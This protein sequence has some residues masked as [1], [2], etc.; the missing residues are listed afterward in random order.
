MT[1]EEEIRSI[2]NAKTVDILHPPILNT[3]DDEQEVHNKLYDEFNEKFVTRGFPVKIV[4]FRKFNKSIR[5]DSSCKKWGDVHDSLEDLI[6]FMPESVMKREIRVQA[7]NLISDRYTTGSKRNPKHEPDRSMLPAKENK[8]RPRSE[9]SIKSSHPETIKIDNVWSVEKID[10]FLSHRG[11][12]TMNENPNSDQVIPIF[13]GQDNQISFQMKFEDALMNNFE[14]NINTSRSFA[15]CVAQE[16]ILSTELEESNIETPTI[17]CSPD[18]S[19]SY[20][21]SKIVP[22]SMSAP[23]QPLAEGII[24]PAT[25]LPSTKVL[26]HN[27]NFW[28]SG[29]V[30]SAS[31]WHHDGNSNILLVLHGRKLIELCPPDTIQASAIYSDHANHPAVLCTKDYNLYHLNRSIKETQKSIFTERYI[32]DISAGDSIFIPPGWWHRVESYGPCLAVNIWFNTRSNSVHSL[33]N[34]DNLHMLSF[35]AR[36]LVRLYYTN[37]YIS[38]AVKYM[39]QIRNDNNLQCKG[40]IIN[41]IYTQTLTN[42]NNIKEMIIKSSQEPNCDKLLSTIAEHLNRSFILLDIRSNDDRKLV[43]K[44]LDECFASCPKSEKLSRIITKLDAVSCFVIAETWN[45][46][47]KHDVRLDQQSINIS[48]K[49]FAERCGHYVDDVM[50]FL[51]SSD[52]KFKRIIGQKLILDHLLAGNLITG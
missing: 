13:M 8:K 48:I 9:T 47:C 34:A 19:V 39:E 10:E 51:K 41:N 31:N 14:E 35:Q 28:F 46:Q 15:Y 37:N 29:N 17:L 26:I 21:G 42:I 24:C 49:S 43:L 36:E 32:V 3:E 11:C 22:E 12:Q 2:C 4:D 50:A 30:I 18:G 25:L 44:I 16:P 38:A 23:L 1:E 45:N 5:D 52:E 6:S 33:T 40:S 7:V 20:L 27:I